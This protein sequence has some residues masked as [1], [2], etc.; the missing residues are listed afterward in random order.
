MYSEKKMGQLNY[1]VFIIF[2]GFQYIVVGVSNIIESKEKC[3]GDVWSWF[4]F[5]NSKISENY[6][7]QSEDNKKNFHS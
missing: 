2:F 6:P 5:K 1:R 3:V 4:L 7:I